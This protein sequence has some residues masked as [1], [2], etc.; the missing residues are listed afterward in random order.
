MELSWQEYWSRLPF[1]TPGDFPNPGIRPTSPVAPVLQADSLLLSHQEVFWVT[2]KKKVCKEMDNGRRMET[3][4]SYV[5]F[6]LY[7]ENEQICASF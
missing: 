5:P 2:P 1:P 4:C 7:E 3:W 6:L